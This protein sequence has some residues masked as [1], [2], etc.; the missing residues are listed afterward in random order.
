[1]KY[2]LTLKFY[3]IKLDHNYKNYQSS[4]QKKYSGVDPKHPDLA[5]KMVAFKK[6]NPTLTGELFLLPLSTSI[7]AASRLGVAGCEDGSSATSRTTP[8][9]NSAF[10][11]SH[12][13]Q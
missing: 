8:G 13:N 11:K 2:Y 4:I 6:K 12:L 7:A 1:L 3:T 9:P 10:G 5:V